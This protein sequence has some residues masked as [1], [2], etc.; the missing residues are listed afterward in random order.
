L[1]FEDQYREEHKSEEIQ[2]DE[3]RANYKDRE[4]QVDG[5]LKKDEATDEWIEEVGQETTP[6]MIYYS[7]PKNI[8]LEDQL[9]AVYFPWE[10]GD[11]VC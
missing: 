5:P 4:K 2:E 8:T 10:P 11:Q 9:F 3:V 6:Q 1:E 7:T